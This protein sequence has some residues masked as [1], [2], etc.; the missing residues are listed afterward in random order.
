M[1]LQGTQELYFDTVSQAFKMKSQPVQENLL[2]ILQ[3][4]SLP[5]LKLV[6]EGSLMI[7]STKAKILLTL[8]SST[9]PPRGP[10]LWLRGEMPKETIRQG[11]THSLECFKHLHMYSNFLN[12]QGHSADE[13][14]G[15]TAAGVDLSPGTNL[16]SLVES[17]SSLKNF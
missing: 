7:S 9:S 15:L 8:F 5:S 16:T 13:H 4:K 11:F 2:K 14:Q 17:N 3:T 6:E 10:Q 12:R 1:W